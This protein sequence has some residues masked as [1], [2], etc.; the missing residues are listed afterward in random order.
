[1]KTG[2]GAWAAR[3]AVIAA[4]SVI[5]GGWGA[6]GAGAENDDITEVVLEVRAAFS[7]AVL[8]VDD[9]GHVEYLARSSEAGADE[10]ADAEI[11]AEGF[12]ALV[13]VIHEAGFFSLDESYRDESIMDATGYAVSVR[14]EDEVKKVSC[15]AACP[16]ALRRIIDTIRELWGREIIEVG[17]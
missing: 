3:A 15:Y 1:M 2:I 10:T 16:E 9:R 6:A 5:I 7:T 13:V 14:R 4:L 8:T 12:S 11:G 17:A